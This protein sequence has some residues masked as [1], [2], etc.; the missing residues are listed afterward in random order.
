[1]CRTAVLVGIAG[2]TFGTPVRHLAVEHLFGMSVLHEHI[3]QTYVRN[4]HV[5]VRVEHLFDCLLCKLDL[6]VNVI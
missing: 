1:M 2:Q 3:C 5:H 4:P 6:H